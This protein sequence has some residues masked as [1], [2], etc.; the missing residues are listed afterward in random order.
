MAHVR[1]VEQPALQSPPN[2]HHNG[3]PNGYLSP[4]SDHTHPNASSPHVKHGGGGGGGGGSGSGGS[5]LRSRDG[6]RNGFGSSSNQGSREDSSDTALTRT[7][8]LSSGSRGSR[9]LIV[10]DI[11][12]YNI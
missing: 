6:A 10:T 3:M 2:Q 12:G 5:R 4:E 9:Y 11:Y 1:R 8:S 7:K